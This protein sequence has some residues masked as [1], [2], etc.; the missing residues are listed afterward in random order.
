M[1]LRKVAVSSKYEP[2]IIPASGDLEDWDSFV[3]ESPQGC[4]FCRSW[5]LQAVAPDSFQ[6]LV[7][8]RGG[9]IVAGMPLVRRATDIVMPPL[10]QTLGV[11]LVPA[12]K[13]T[14]EARLSEEIDV[15]RELVSAVPR[16]GRFS[17]SFHYQFANWLHF[18]WAGFKQTTR[19][20]YAIE[21]LSDMEAV[22]AGFAHS[23]RKNLKRAE[24]L[25][26]VLEDMPCD[27]FY[28]HHVM[29][30]GKLGDR[31]SY[32]H[33]LFKR[34]YAEAYSHEAGKTWSAVDGK[35]NVHAAIFVVFDRKSAYYLISTI[36]PDF[37]DSG[38]TTLLLRQ[39]MIYV[40]RYTYRFDFEGSMIESVET[41]FRRFGAK[42]IPY[43]SITK[44]NRPLPLRVVPALRAGAGRMLRRLGLRK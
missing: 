32:G 10:T 11:L 43:F 4:I 1:R 27:E 17:V 42:Q 14:Y 8:R 25:V 39:A 33:S 3:D 30:L 35:G 40:S 24:S 19:Y 21:D 36:D 5:W 15:L 7:L 22:V 18:Y 34:L 9:R 20:S 23:K 29:T 31:I 12:L 16:F 26:T 44:D 6:I 28:Y 38:A 13:K 37:R 41:S 2:E